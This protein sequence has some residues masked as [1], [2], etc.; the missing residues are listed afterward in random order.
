MEY[1]IGRNRKCPKDVVI[2]AGDGGLTLNQGFPV[3]ILRVASCHFHEPAFNLNIT[4]IVFFIPHA[5][6]RSLSISEAWKYYHT[7][8]Q[9]Y[10]FAFY[11]FFS[12][13]VRN[14]LSI[15]HFSV[16]VTTVS[17]LIMGCHFSQSHSV[18]SAPNQAFPVQACPSWLHHWCL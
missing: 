2:L 10:N 17:T 5:C 6:L 3:V 12:C 18:F 13:R 16:W 4:L 8:L 15:I 9:K 1:R 14:R 11:N 7:A